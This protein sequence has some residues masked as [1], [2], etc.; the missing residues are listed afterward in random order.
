VSK[1]KVHD[2]RTS[3]ASN[4]PNSSPRASV[5]TFTEDEI[6]S[7]AYQIYEFRNRTD[8]HAA[9]DWS[10]AETELMEMVGGK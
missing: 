3:A 8:D 2:N 1:T 6:R 10:Q 4:Q 7:R 5:G 9:E